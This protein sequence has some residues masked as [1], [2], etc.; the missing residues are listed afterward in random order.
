VET[1]IRSGGVDGFVVV[2]VV[3]AAA[4][5]V[6]GAVL[7]DVVAALVRFGGVDGFVTVVVAAASAVGV[8]GA[9]LRDVVATLVRFGGVCGC[10]PLTVVGDVLLV[11]RLPVSM[12]PK[13]RLYR[14]QYKQKCIINFID[15]KT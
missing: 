8:S 4:V 14:L 2:V 13:P 7:R 10:W 11:S 12:L 1:L 6:S 15:I 3:A 9:V 5:G